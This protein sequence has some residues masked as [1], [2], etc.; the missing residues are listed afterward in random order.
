MILII[1]LIVLV[2]LIVWFISANNRLVRY[3]NEVEKAES[4]IGVQ[5]TR[6][7]DLIPN[8]VE[9]VKGYTSHEE[10]TLTQVTEM[11]NS[12]M[13]SDSS[14]SE[15]LKANDSMSSNLK[16]LMVSVEAYPKLK[17]NTNFLNLQEELAN[18]ENKVS[19]SRLSYN[20]T[21]TAFN[22]MIESF[23]LNIVAAFK[24]YKRKE[25]LESPLGKRAEAPEIKF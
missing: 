22:N 13:S 1:G 21:V 15:K 19:F 6:R 11:R 14:L 17:A 5:L 25:V 20:S 12:I 8:L 7:A 23:P 10:K 3:K 24:R 18:T 4:N 16:Q 2:L 9:T